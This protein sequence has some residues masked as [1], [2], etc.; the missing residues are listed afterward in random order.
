MIKASQEYF[1]CKRKSRQNFQEENVFELSN[2]FSGV[3]L[4]EF[5]SIPTV[6]TATVK[7]HSKSI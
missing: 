1:Y 5:M 6:P 3:T 2:V 4:L 7:S